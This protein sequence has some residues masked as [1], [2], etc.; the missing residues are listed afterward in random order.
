MSAHEARG[1]KLAEQATIQMRVAEASAEID[2]ARLLLHRATFETMESMYRDGKL[3]L[4]QRARNRRDMAYTVT[5]CSRAADRLFTGTGGA[6]LYAG[7]PMQR[8]FRDVRAVGAHYIN[9]WDIAGTTYGRVTLGLP[10][11]HFAI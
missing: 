4:E 5:L 3:S 9:S 2:S 6:G 7:N 11:G 10:P 1:V 8:M